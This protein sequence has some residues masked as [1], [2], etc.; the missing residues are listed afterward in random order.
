MKVLVTGA[1]GLVGKEIIK[2]L[3]AKGIFVHY[4][5]TSRNKLTHSDNT[6]GF[7]WN[8]QKGEIDSACIEGVHSIIHLA[9]ASISKRW[10]SG[11]KQ[12]IINSRIL[13]MQIL[14]K[15]LQN[16]PNEVKNIVTASAIGVYP[17]CIE[18]YYTE[19]FLDF[20]DSFLSNVVKK[21]E[22]SADKFIHLGVKVCKLRIG[23]VLSKK[24]GVLPEILNPLQ[25]G[26]GV[27]FGSGQQWQSWIHIKD[28]ARLFVFTLDLQLQ[29][30]YNAVA[31]DPV[32]HKEFMFILN[33]FLEKPLI[34]V[35]LPKFLMKLILGEKH[36]LLYDSQRVS[37]LK[38]QQKGFQF[39]YAN[40]DDAL[41]NLLK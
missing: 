3:Y 13:P 21:W 39:L 28:L 15:L 35:N 2:I 14:Y 5:T 6:K 10:T 26:L 40:L 38:I 23:L 4:L 41:N 9:G 18:K 19:D 12:E 11:Y 8:P 17:S 7:Y 37:S 34:V 30:I 22:E 20:D 1:T 16:T 27:L 24:G 25:V 33:R 36:V 29:G 32:T 31:P